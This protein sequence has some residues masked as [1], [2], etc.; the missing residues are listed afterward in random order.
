LHSLFARISE[1][2]RLKNWELSASTLKWTLMADQFAI[3][4]INP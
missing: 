2:K 1:I 3:V 4:M